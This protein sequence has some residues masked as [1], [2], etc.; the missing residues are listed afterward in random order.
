MPRRVAHLDDFTRLWLGQTLSALGSQA[1]GTAFSL[2][3][4]LTVAASPAQLGLLGALRAIPALLLGLAAGV[5]V[6][7]LTR[8][9]LL[10]AADFGRALLLGG[11][12][13]LGASGALRFEALCVIAFLVAGLAVLFDVAYP[14]YT[15]SLV[16]P[17]RLVAAN[18]RL[19]MGESVAEIIGPGLGGWLTQA[20]GAASAIGLDAVS[21]LLSALS[22]ATIR[23]YEP[24]PAPP[25]TRAA[26]HAEARAGLA[27]TWQH[28]VL[29][30]LLLAD[31][32]LALASGWIGTLFVLFVTQTLGLAPALMGALVGVGGLS[33]LPGAFLAERVTRRLG[34]VRAMVVARLIGAASSVLTVFAGGPPA[35]ATGMLALAQTTDASWAVFG[36]AQQALRQTVTPNALLGRV[37]ATTRLVTGVLLPLGALMGGS[38]AEALGVR[39]ALGLGFLVNAAAIGPLLVLR[40][41]DP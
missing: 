31:A 9:P 2:L 39:V 15:P 7:R 23:R 20:V 18:A 40:H 28:P 12:A 32:L 11:L 10:M 14:A 16:A 29:R 13:L 27:V 34:L 22:L 19:A 41:P 21:F 26:W 3:A 36:A 24:P 30:G 35:V 33:A 4:I 8:R 25:A 38:V 37:S 5:W 17:D 6:D 1:G